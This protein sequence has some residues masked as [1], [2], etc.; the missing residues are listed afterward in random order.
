MT[1]SLSATTSVILL[2]TAPLTAGGRGAVSTPDLLTV[3]EYQRLADHLREP[4]DLIGP[5]APEALRNSA[6]IIDTH[7]LQRLLARGL[8]LG[9]AVEYWQARNIWV[10]SQHDAPYPQRLTAHLAADAPLILY[11]CGNI[12][13]LGGLAVVGSHCTDTTL[14]DEAH[15]IGHLAATAGITI[16]CGSTTNIE[17]AARHSALKAGGQACGIVSCA[18]ETAI[19]K[20]QHRN[21][22]IADQLTL[23][24]PYDPHAAFH[25]SRQCHQIIYALSDASIV[26]HAEVDE[27]GPWIYAMEHLKRGATVYS[28]APDKPAAGL[29]ALFKQG[30]TPWPKPQDARSLKAIITPQREAVEDSALPSYAPI[31][32]S[33]RIFSAIKALAPQLLAQAMSSKEVA[34]AW[35]IEPKTALAWLKR[36]VKEGIIK[37]KAA[38][39]KTGQPARY[40]YD[41]QQRL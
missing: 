28:L 24:S 5:N 41:R 26:I 3:S 15:A 19:M 6:N 30:A 25:A 17:Q 2:L 14:L 21:A 22:I 7:R 12:N 8:Q 38:S 40:I 1:A 9:Q 18:L 10:I 37:R 16:V 27:S 4:A 29:Q 36:L 13:R 23:M 11:G 35:G 39:R 33:E 34:E 31:A 20:R 32:P